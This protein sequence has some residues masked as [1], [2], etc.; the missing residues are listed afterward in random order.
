MLWGKPDGPMCPNPQVA[1]E[2]WDSARFSRN[3]P[4][5]GLI[6]LHGA[7]AV[8]NTERRLTASWGCV[9]GHTWAGQLQR[10]YSSLTP[11]LCWGP[12]RAPFLGLHFPAE[13]PAEQTVFAPLS[14]SSL[15]AK[16]SCSLGFI[17]LQKN[18]KN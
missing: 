18:C 4:Y 11:G 8:G 2:V 6:V 10:T 13:L 5:S 9:S 14:F 15:V 17:S 3:I 1:V 7:V 16:S 12:S